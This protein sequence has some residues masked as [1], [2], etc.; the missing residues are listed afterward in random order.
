MSKKLGFLIWTFFLLYLPPIVSIASI[1]IVGI[2]SWIYI[3]ANYHRFKRCFHTLQ[4]SMVFALALFA[5]GYIAFLEL[6][7]INGIDSAVAVPLYL[8]IFAFP[9]SIAYVIKIDKM[10]LTID[11]V[12]KYIICAGTIQGAISIL[13]LFSYSIQNIFVRQLYHIMD[14]KVVDYWRTMRLYGWASGMTYAMPVLSATIGLVALLYAIRVDKKYM[15]TVPVIWASGILNARTSMVVILIGVCCIFISTNILDKKQRRAI[16]VLGLAGISFV[17]AFVVVS[18]LID[19]NNLTRWM[20]NGVSEVFNFFRGNN[21]G[22]FASIGIP[23]NTLELP[24]NLLFGEGYIGTRSDVGYIR[25]MWMGGIVYCGAV[26]ILLS[27]WLRKLYGK[28]KIHSKKLGRAVVIFFAGVFF[29]V[30]VKGQIV[31]GNE[32]VVFF[33]VLV[34]YTLYYKEEA[35]RICSD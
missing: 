35:V 7:N 3:M 19:N 9:A 27:Y 14:P 6:F 8:T 11:V 17:F 16:P 18:T 20:A 12:A 2:L 22:Y 30:N 1:K 26:I 10:H 34:I 28:I 29:S 5:C 23:T 25:D 13:C 33:L 15:I 4:I 24:P 21:T 32:F 31:S